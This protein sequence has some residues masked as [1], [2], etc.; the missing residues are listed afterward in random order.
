MNALQKY[1]NHF[2]EKGWTIGSM[3]DQQFIA[4]KRQGLNSGVALIGVLGLLFYFIPGLLILL[5]GYAARGIETKIVT[6]TEAN[7]WLA[8]EEQRAEKLQTEEE[9]RRVE[10]EVKKVANDKKVAELSGS[11]LRF[12][13]MMSN[14]QRM[15]VVAVVVFLVIMLIALLNG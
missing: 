10:A 6:A 14:D 2:I 12:W 1:A 5:I 11:P 15:L 9:A 13:Y 4:T 8:Q 7:A 3:T